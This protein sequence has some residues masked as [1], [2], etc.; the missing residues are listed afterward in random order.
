[1]KCTF[2]LNPCPAA[3]LRTP[4]LE[5]PVTEIKELSLP[6]TPEEFESCYGDIGIMILTL[7]NQTRTAVAERGQVGRVVYGLPLISRRDP[8]F[9]PIARLKELCDT[10]P[11]DWKVYVGYLN[12]D[13]GNLCP[14]M[15][16][17]GYNA[18]GDFGM[19]EV[20]KTWEDKDGLTVRVHSGAMHRS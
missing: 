17:A 7:A 3:N 13:E 14:Q 1:M 5:I 19:Y 11:D 4:Y 10:V 20:V 9:N 15:Y 18:F 12:T 2:A 6:Q 16:L 8:T